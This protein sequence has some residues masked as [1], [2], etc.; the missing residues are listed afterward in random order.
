MDIDPTIP[1]PP[2]AP[3][4][5]YSEPKDTARI[6]EVMASKKS[7]SELLESKCEERGVTFVPL[8][9]KSREGRPVFKMGESMQCYVIRNVIM[10]SKDSGRT[11]LPI[12]ME[13]LLSM[14][15][16]D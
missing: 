10:Y 16:D 5:S 1:A 6:C 15:E 7:F 11:Y 9:G 2:P 12:S 4:I 14:A 8:P 13:K 3:K